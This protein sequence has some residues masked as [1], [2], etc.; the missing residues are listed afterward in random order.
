MKIVEGAFV[1][2]DC[3]GTRNRYDRQGGVVHGGGHLY[4]IMNVHLRRR[5]CVR[6]SAR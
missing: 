2:I 1:A 3:V 5:S 4:G 6:I